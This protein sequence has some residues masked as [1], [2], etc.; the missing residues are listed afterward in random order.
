MPKN[1]KIR[2]QHKTK[3]EPEKTF[4]Q[5]SLKE[6]DK[7]TKQGTMLGSAAIVEKRLADQVKA[8]KTLP[9]RYKI[10]MITEWQLNG[11]VFKGK[12]YFKY[13]FAKEIGIS[14]DEMDKQLES[15]K[16][17]F[18]QQYESKAA[19]RKT[20]ADLVH[21]VGFYLKSD[22]ARVVLHADLFDQEIE[23]LLE[24]RKKLD[25]MPEG[26]LPDAERK[27]KALR[28]WHSDFAWTTNQRIE[29]IKLLFGSTAAFNRYLEHFSGVRSQRPGDKP[30]K[31]LLAPEDEGEEG[32]AKDDFVTPARA[33]ELL[34]ARGSVLPTQGVED[35]NEG[36][37]N[38]DESFDDFEEPE[39]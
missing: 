9:L 24:K 16:T 36:P 7:K 10:E 18:S 17:S 29:A 25:E 12:R 13:D 8:W 21:N 6:L 30:E 34:D 23:Y 26:T 1:Q 2:P 22:R 28:D 3:S 32:E 4:L 15:I 38:P 11:G 5:K 33:I 19:I 14:E 20:V 35:I 39:K 37:R 27:Q 31:P